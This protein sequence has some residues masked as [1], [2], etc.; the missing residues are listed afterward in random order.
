MLDVPTT[1]ESLVLW[2]ILGILSGMLNR[3]G[4]M[5]VDTIV[6]CVSDAAPVLWRGLTGRRPIRATSDQPV[7]ARRPATPRFRGI[8][9]GEHGARELVDV[10]TLPDDDPRR[11]GPWSCEGDC[12][13]P[14]QYRRTT[15]DGSRRA[16]L[17][18]MRGAVHG[19]GCPQA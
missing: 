7:P 14:V 3:I 11:S 15:S 8:Y 12:G 16:S 19:L 6:S 5:I 17:V 10:R 1:P 13:M 4:E 9:E 2:L 18:R